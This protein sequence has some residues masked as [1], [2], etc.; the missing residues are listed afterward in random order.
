M[1]KFL[2]YFL[3]LI[4]SF[5]ASGC[6]Y[7]KSPPAP[8]RMSVNAAKT[9]Q[10]E[11]ARDFAQSFAYEKKNEAKQSVESKSAKIKPAKPVKITDPAWKSIQKQKTKSEKN[12]TLTELIDMALTNNPQTRQDWDQ[13]RVSRAI[14][15]QAESTLYPQLTIAAT[16]TREKQVSNIPAN[17]FNDT[18][19]GPSA[20]LT[21]LILDFGGRGANIESKFQK[22]L[23]A[24][25]QYNQSLQDLILN[26]Q[27]TYYNYYAAQSQAEA[28]QLD[29]QNTKVD[30]DAAQAKFDVGLVPKLDVLQAKSN[31]ENSLYNLESAKGKVKTSKADLALAIGV[32]ADTNFDIVSPTKELPTGINEDDVSRLIEEAMQKRPDIAA[33]KA[34]LKSKQAAVKA[35]LSDMLP[36][37]SV[38]GSVQ[39]NKYKY[40]NSGGLKDNQR[41]YSG[42]ASV[43]WDIFD[44]FSNLNIKKQADAESAVALDKLIQ[45]ELSAS[46]DVWVKYYDFNTAVQKLQFGQAYFDTT[47]NSYSLA[48]ESYN[49]GLKSI[50]DLT[51]AQSD[52]SAARSRLIQSKQDVFVSLA[53]LAHSTGTPNIK[54]EAVK[55]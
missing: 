29:V 49:A 41:D 45:A 9:E 25:A 33:L 6:H 32:S 5:I 3:L 4:L 47:E 54:I 18:H 20:Q 46:S 37:V 24:N 26:V 51:Q 43:S 52:L 44:G 31:Y 17:R 39:D 35:A 48:L 50:L 19:Y 38:G 22:V 14:E 42:Y 55:N 36:S 7:L 12:Y 53:A 40:V 2:L 8:S 21:W 16:G 15:K 28:A 10:A 23:E 30:Y 27:K 1:N 34:E 13:I 11:D